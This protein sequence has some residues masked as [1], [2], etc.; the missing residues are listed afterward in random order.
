MFDPALP[1]VSFPK[2]EQEIL[3]LWRTQET[4]R[5]SLKRRRHAPRYVVYERPLTAHAQPTAHHVRARA[6]QDLF[7]RYKTMRGYHVLHQDGWDAHGLPVELAI[8]REF[9]LADKSIERFNQRC[10]DLVFRHVEEWKRWAERI[11]FWT[12]LERAYATL[13]NEYIES[14][15]WVLKQL[16]ERSLIY[17]DY[18]VAPYCPR[19]CT[20]LANYEA[21]LGLRE[22]V[23]VPSVYVKF[24]LRD[25][26]GT[27]FLV[28][29]AAPWTLP[30]NVALAV[31][32]D[33][34]YLEVEQ[35]DG[36]GQTERLIVAEARREALNDPYQIVR[37]MKGKA[38]LGRR[39]KPLYTFLPVDNAAYAS[40][41]PGESIGMD[42]G[43]G[44]VHVAPAFGASD[45]ET[46]LRHG[47]PVLQ[48]VDLQGRFTEAVTPWRGLF[49]KDADPLIVEELR[50]R[51]LLYKS[52]TCEHTYPFCPYCETPLLYYAKN[53]WFIA[54]SRHRDRLI[55]HHRQIHWHPESLGERVAEWLAGHEDW[56]LSR[57]RYWGTPLPFWVCDACGHQECIGSVAE[58]SERSGIPL[59]LR[60]RGDT[61]SSARHGAPQPID[62]H[63]PYVDEIVWRCPRCS[64]ERSR[65]RPGMMRRVPEVADPWFDSGAM[66]LALWHYP[67][68]NPEAF[69]EQFPADLI[70]EATDQAPGWSYTVHAIAVLLF[71]QP[72]YRNAV[73]LGLMPGDQGQR[74]SQ[75]HGNVADLGEAL[76]T[77]GA[78]ALRW[79]LYTAAL[80]DGSHPF[81]EALVREAEQ[82]FL[83]PLWDLYR[84]FVSHVHANR[85]RLE[86]EP[87]PR[88]RLQPLD[89]W[90]LSELNRLIL[91]VTAWLDEYD[92]ASAARAIAIFLDD[93]SG[94]YVRHSRRRLFS[95]ADAGAFDDVSKR[96]ASHTLYICLTILSRLLAPF[97]PFLAEWMH[98][99]LVRRVQVEAP[100]SVH[101]C[102]WP[103]ADTAWIDEALSAEVR[104]AQRIARL[105]HAARQAAQVKAHQPLAEAAV[106]LRSPE[107]RPALDRVADQIVEELNVKALRVIEQPG[108]LIEWPRPPYSIASEGGYM[109][110]VNTALT[111]ALELEGEAR[112]LVWHIQELRRQAGLAWSDRIITYVRGQGRLADVLAAF[113]DSVAEETLSVR[114]DLAAPPAEAIQ[115]ALRLGGEQVTVGIVRA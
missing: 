18:K 115:R 30:S 34:M 1:S 3:A 21:A 110:A 95:H 84:F 73:G 35:A 16:W 48:P 96:A 55:A 68:E 72:S 8:E 83:R 31:A 38:L 7:L 36:E 42:E 25:Q 98:Q 99:H 105:G 60:R 28:W 87:V 113:Q 88:E 64:A 112:E 61:A 13:H 85:W 65:T 53:T 44:I 10:R 27:Y 81:S 33:A 67:F 40:V 4:F 54:T 49:V 109:V 69:T 12:D 20:S 43:T 15:W 50:A 2:A 100:E 9:G 17:R 29:T 70:C 94:W 102:D 101:L 32:P 66:P 57:D 39:Y 71:D 5:K 41:I 62:L 75:S 26:P 92:V 14:L 47:L 52:G 56:A 63:R 22:D 79:H 103:Q 108:D 37:R 6:W 51:G 45:M 78:D 58:L 107:E 11:G 19:C 111:P 80:S 93:L 114:L 77:H 76:N 46:A 106:W 104:L 86:G 24:P 74:M 59:R 90:I 23:P 97:T 89:R 82:R 91:Q